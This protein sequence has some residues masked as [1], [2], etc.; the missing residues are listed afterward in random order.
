MNARGVMELVIASIAF[1][2]GV[3]DGEIFSALLAVGLVT[4][5]LTPLLL[6]RWQALG[7]PASS[8]TSAR[9]R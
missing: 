7:T 5:A 3:V 1:R 8:S 4:T 9:V 2:A 6:Q